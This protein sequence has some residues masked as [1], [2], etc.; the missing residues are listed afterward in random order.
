M[1][2]FANRP[3]PQGGHHR[4]KAVI[5]AA[6]LALALLLAFAAP[7]LAKDYSMGP[8]NISAQV[9][10]DGSMSVVEERTFDFADDFSRVYWDLSKTD[11]GAITVAGIEEIVGGQALPYV[12][13]TST[14]PNTTREPGTFWVSDGAEAVSVHAYFRKSGEPATFRLT[15]TVAGAAKRWQDTA[16][17][18]WKFVGSQ[19]GVATSDLSVTIKPPAALTKDQVQ[20]WAHGPLTGAVAIEPDGTVTL[21]APFVPAET[22][23]EGRILYPAS[24]LPGAPEI[25]QPRRESVLAEE[26]ALARKANA[27]RLM[28]R[29]AIYFA[30]YGVGLISLGA[31]G[32]ALWAFFRFGREHKPQFEGKYFRE[33]PRPDLAPA[34]VGA[35]W[36]FGGVEDSDIAATLMNLADKGIVSMQ[37]VTDTKKGLF[38]AK[39]IKTFELSLVPGREQELTGLDA[40][41]TSLL[42]SE[43]GGGVPVRLEDIKSYAKDHA[44]EFS[45]SIA[46]WKASSSAQA[47]QLG[48]LEPGGESWQV[49]LMVL[50]ISLG[51]V[52]IFSAVWSEVF[53]ASVTPI[54]CAIAIAIISRFMK[55]R[56]KEG[57]ELNGQYVALRNYLR[58]FSRLKEAPPASV[59]IWNRF[60]VL[61]VVFGIAEEVI[62]Q[63]RVKVPEVVQDPGFAM[64]YWWV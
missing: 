62:A 52:G 56:S 17:L 19:W 11:A 36:R 27:E 63:L 13:S 48:L 20:A 46:Q 6:V 28:N 29:L 22:F 47:D 54:L 33:D 59:V 16:E 14:D 25:S 55:R 51:I 64:T 26:G 49:G 39:E 61:A 32:F 9:N 10:P 12:P 34:V 53:V 21:K 24:A 1:I 2:R 8:V 50:A 43:I 4:A 35:L 7:A 44:K 57:A 58:D 30:I 15:Y 60:L 42:F 41:L 5:L 37:A 31:L 40:N 38:G 23:V 3:G 45:E 18:Y